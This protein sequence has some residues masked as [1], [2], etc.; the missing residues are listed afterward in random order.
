MAEWGRQDQTFLKAE[1]ELK[2]LLI[3]ITQWKRVLE[4]KKTL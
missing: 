4:N 3:K 1:E 2:G